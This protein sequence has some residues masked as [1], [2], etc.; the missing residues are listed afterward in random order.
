MRRSILFTCFAV[1][2]LSLFFTFGESVAALSIEGQMP[3]FSEMS[4]TEIMKWREEFEKQNEKSDPYP[5]KQNDDPKPKP[6][7][8]INKLAPLAPQSSRKKAEDFIKQCPDLPLPINL[9]AVSAQ[10]IGA[11]YEVFESVQEE[12]EVFREKTDLLLKAIEEEILEAEAAAVKYAASIHQSVTLDN[13]YIQTVEYEMDRIRYLKM[14]AILANM[15]DELSACKRIIRHK[16]EYQKY[17]DEVPELPSDSDDN[18]ADDKLDY[19]KIGYIHMER[20]DECNYEW[21]VY[22]G[23]VQSRIKAKLLDYAVRTDELSAQLTMLST[24]EGLRIAK[25][26]VNAAQDLLYMPPEGRAEELELEIENMKEE[27]RLKKKN[28]DHKMY[29]IALNKTSFV[30]GGTIT[31]EVSDLLG[32]AED[33][34][35]PFVG[36]YAIGEKHEKYLSEKSISDGNGSYRLNAPLEPGEYEVRAYEKSRGD[37]ENLIM[38]AAFTVEGDVKSAYKIA[39]DKTSFLPGGTITVKV[40]GVPEEML[41][42]Y[43]FVGVY[44]IGGKH[45]EGLSSKVILKR[46]ESLLLN[47]PLEPGEYEVR[48]YAKRDVYVDANLVAKAAFTIGGDAKGAYKIALDKTS[49][50]PGGTI[51]VNVSDVPGE[52]LSDNPIVGV[53]AMGVE[54]KNDLTNKRISKSVESLRLNAPL[55]PGEYEVRAY[56]K[57]YVYVD[58]NLVAKETFV[59]GGDAKGAYKI[60]LEK[61]SFLPGG[62]I[63]VNVSGVPGEMLNDEPFVGVYATDGEHGKDI[64]SK[65]ISK[66]A[67]SLRLNA[68]LEPGEYEV[69]AYAKRYVYVD[70]NL[71]AKAAFT[72]GGDVKGA[73]KIA[74]EKT[75]FLPKGAITVN[76]SDV[77]GEILNEGPCVAVYPAGGNHKEY[78]SSM[79]ISRSAESLRLNAPL[80]PGEY[81]VRAYAKHFVYTD[82]TLVTKTSAFTV[83]KDAKG[84][85]KLALDKTSY[86]PREKIT[87]NVSGVP[88]WML[89]CKPFAAVYETGARHRG[90]QSWG[91]IKNVSDNVMLLAP[92]EEGEYEVRGYGQDG[93]YIDSDLVGTVRFSVKKR[94]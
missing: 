88:E 79:K 47:A 73:F 5:Q 87:V 46:V 1:L 69:R 76:V 26:Y 50:F 89:S 56:A 41:N 81:E 43:P 45:N 64:S 86:V 61:K 77:P 18:T 66:S 65:K 19:E 23:R 52:M 13:D 32:K 55:E 24:C 9:L 67:E 37:D 25:E 72:V 29:R 59:V 35:F 92:K 12:I 94:E 84:I 75:S 39:L 74:L 85:Y 58:A 20:D 38:K 44:A 80:K 31:V 33:F 6:K 78:L 57:Q 68:P 54:H 21:Y 83:I 10:E 63:T 48:A 11:Y 22:I 40:S 49:F 16:E 28:S 93:V 34:N 71:V 90:Y 27:I 14:K 82:A 7:P 70:A 15:E 17:I 8:D 91:H 42:E 3:D 30:P 53:Y 2:V 62:A 51:T 60:A 4:F 36:V